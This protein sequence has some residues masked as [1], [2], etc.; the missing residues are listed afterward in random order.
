MPTCL[1]KVLHTKNNLQSTIKAL[2]FLTISLFT[3]SLF[4]Q[5]KRLNGK[6]LNTHDVEGIH[7]LN[8]SSRFNAVTNSRGEFVITVKP[9]D[10]LV[11]SSVAFIPDQLI[12]TKQFYDD[13][14][15]AITLKELVTQ[16]DEVMLGPRL[17]GNLEQDIKNIKIIDTLNFD[18]VGIPGFKG[19]PEEKIAPIVPVI[20][21]SVNIE[22]LYNH[23]S[24]YYRKL[25]LQR[26]WENENIMISQI[27]RHY[28]PQF[29]NEAYQIPE[30]RLYDFLLFCVETSDIE[31]DFKKEK[32]NL[33][34]ETFAKQG[35]EYILRLS[36]KEE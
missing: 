1:D 9:L 33:V 23:L 29:F 5:E 8:K 26:K 34:L 36:E 31:H 16:L 24:G 27:I 15:M 2:L 28:T 11:I 32:H 4:G 3:V 12:V 7:I 19:K 6:I 35:K 13:G 17:S 22:A 30:E 18:D 20:P 25:R 14:L 10:T 21:L